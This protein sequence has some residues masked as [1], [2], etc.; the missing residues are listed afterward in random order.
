VITYAYKC[1]ACGHIFEARQRMTAEAL[2]EC[3]ACGGPVRRLITG[4]LGVLDIAHDSSRACSVSG[5]G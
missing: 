3:P 1:D 2:R 5:G 4:G